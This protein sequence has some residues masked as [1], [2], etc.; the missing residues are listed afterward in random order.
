MYHLQFTP[1]SSTAGLASVSKN[2]LGLERW[3]L[4]SSSCRDGKMGCM[5][6]GHAS[7]LL[8]DDCSESLKT[9]PQKANGGVFSQAACRRRQVWGSSKRADWVSVSFGDVEKGGL[10]HLCTVTRETSHPDLFRSG[11]RTLQ[12]SKQSLQHGCSFSPWWSVQRT[13]KTSLAPSLCGDGFW[14]ALLHPQDNA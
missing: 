1:R 7:Y 8:A 2:I 10:L 12:A 4:N 6:L 13:K 11:L 3:G 5:L 14:V 9:R